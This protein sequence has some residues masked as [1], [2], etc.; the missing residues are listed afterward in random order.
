MLRGVAV[1]VVR[2]LAAVGSWFVGGGASG[3]SW[4]ARSGLQQEWEKEGNGSMRPGGSR[5][6]KSWGG[7]RLYRGITGRPRRRSSG[8]SR[9]QRL[10]EGE[11]V[12]LVCFWGYGE[13]VDASAEA[14]GMLI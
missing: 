4:F 7:G 8:R 9:A 10:F 5:S 13:E 1:L 14:R 12:V 2:E 6:S 3:W 11:W